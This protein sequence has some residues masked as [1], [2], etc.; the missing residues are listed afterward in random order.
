MALWME[1]GRSPRVLVLVCRLLAMV[2]IDAS[3]SLDAGIS[4][5]ARSSSA[6]G[7]ST[8]LSVSPASPKSMVQCGPINRCTVLSSKNW[9]YKWALNDWT[10]SFIF[11]EWLDRQDHTRNSLHPRRWRYRHRQ[12]AGQIQVGCRRL[13]PQRIVRGDGSHGAGRGMGESPNFLCDQ[14]RNQIG[15]LVVFLRNL[16][17]ELI[18]NY[19]LEP[20]FNSVQLF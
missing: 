3:M 2:C 15:T 5:L 9:T 18:L 12:R 7:R 14:I 20:Q 6:P 4:S 19:H 17:G 16:Q 11:C 8:P 10:V 13:L 1:C